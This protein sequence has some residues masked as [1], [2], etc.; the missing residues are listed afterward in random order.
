MG[1]ADHLDKSQ[2]SPQQVQLA[3]QVDHSRAPVDIIAESDDRER[4]IA[5]ALRRQEHP[6]ERHQ[7]HARSTRRDC[8]YIAAGGSGLLTR[9]QLIDA[10][11]H[12][13]D[14]R[15]VW[16][17]QLRPHTTLDER[18]VIRRQRKRR[19]RTKDVGRRSGNGCGRPRRARVLRHI[20]YDSNRLGR[21]TADNQ[22][23][24]PSHSSRNR[25]HHSRIKTP[26]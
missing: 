18:Q 14:F 1:C 6:H 13:L 9:R 22:Q 12:S 19:Q 3:A 17:A 20:R 23:N 26:N 5:A 21:R 8:S 24:N 7:N 4:G 11:G 16:L 2:L 15:A 25:S 10:G